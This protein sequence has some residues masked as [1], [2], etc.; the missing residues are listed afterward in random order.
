M[1]A[2]KPP[3]SREPDRQAYWEGIY[4][5]IE[6]R[7]GQVWAF[8]GSSHMGFNSGYVT[9]VDGGDPRPLFAFEPP[10]GPEDRPDSGRPTMPITHVLEENGELLVF[11]YSDILRVD[12]TLKSW[13]KVATLEIQYRSGR[14]DAVGSYPAVGVVHPPLRKGEPYVIAT[15]GD[16]YVLMDGA[17]VTA[18]GLPGQLGASGVSRVMNSSEGT[19]FFEDDDRLPVWSLGTKGWEVASLA[20]P[21]E[22]DPANDAAELEKDAETWY[23]TRVLVGPGGAIYTVSGTGVIDGTR[24][25]G[26]RVGGK[27]LRLGRETSSL[28][29]SSSFITADGI[30]WNTS[31]GGLKRFEKGRW[32]TVNEQATPSRLDPINADGPPRLLLDRFNHGLWRLNHGANG[33]DPQLTPVEIREGGK[34][35]QISAGISWSTGTLLL[36]TDL[37]LRTYDPAAQRLSKVDLPEDPPQA[38][39]VLARDGIGR[40]WLGCKNGLWMVEAGGKTA[41]P[42]DRVPWI[43]RNEVESLAP[44]PRHEDGVIVALG[45][46]GVVFIRAAQRR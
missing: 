35:L 42:F 2:I 19:L 26:R 12:K 34:S 31:S 9:R 7:D 36:A 40:L 14:P 20:P 25:T 15:I 8:G 30:L 43:W 46:S 32:Q 29:P 17:K 3:P 6:L 1:A 33:D 13:K 22:I 4:G 39:N 24:T 21:F 18:H 41:E 11:S 45:S 38:V 28:D 27:A 5:F 23:E 44:D 16:G 37:G 10:N